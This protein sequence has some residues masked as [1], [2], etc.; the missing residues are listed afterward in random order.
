[1]TNFIKKMFDRSDNGIMDSGKNAYEMW[2]DEIEQSYEKV[3]LLALKYQPLISVLVPVYNVLD[4]HL[5]ACIES[6]LDQEYPNWELCLVDDC[7]TWPNVKET[8]EKYKNNEKIKIAYRKENGHISECTNTALEMASGE[9]VALLD[10]DDLLSPNALSEVVKVLNDNKDIDFIYSDEDKIEDGGNYRHTPHFKSDWAPDT[11]MSHMYT[12]HLGVYRRSIALEIGGMRKGF[13]GSQDHDFT[14]RFTEK[15]DKVAHISKILYHWRTRPESTAVNSDV[16]PYVIESARRTQEEAVQRRGLKAILEPINGT[17]L[18]RVNYIWEMYPKVSVIIPSKDNY[19][20]LERCIKTFM[21][22]TEYEDYEIIV[23]DNGSSAENK[24]KY[25]KLCEEY[26]IR[27]IYEEREFNFSYMC[28]RGAERATGEYL[29]FLND[30]M[31]IIQSDWLTRMVGHAMLPHIG[32]VGAKLLYPDR[33]TI[34]HDGVINIK[35]GPV[36]AFEGVSNQV[37]CYFGRTILDYNQLAVTAACLLMNRSKFIEVGGFEEGFPVAYNDIELCFKL[38]RK[39]YYNIVR[40]DVALVHYVSSSRGLD[41]DD[42]SKS[43]RLKRE[44]EELYQRYP[45]YD[46]KDPFYNCNLPQDKCDVELDYGFYSEIR[47]AERKQRW[48]KDG[49][50]FAIDEVNMEGDDIKIRGWAF[51]KA[52]NTFGQKATYVILENAMRESFC[53]NTGKIER[54]DV[55]KVF[56]GNG[57]YRFSGFL[58]I[59]KKSS[60]SPGIY[61]IGLKMGRKSILTDKTLEI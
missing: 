52:G 13:E 14:L 60:F 29:L 20:M 28:N 26:H 23:V 27:Y 10:C 30:D 48:N 9:F 22:L 5:I 40:N 37:F 4:R 24:G 50:R 59:I 12:C 58:C 38:V 34:Q 36:H 46:G 55:D 57:R 2:I 44:L 32:A 47:K 43:D 15:T 7:S 31:E 17:P 3:D 56:Q 61:Q 54:P 18:H 45:E 35:N 25:Q 39:G 6:V 8:L 1:M 49:I 19:V 53:C 51:D 11:L 21:E 33:E 42:V 41:I 16:K